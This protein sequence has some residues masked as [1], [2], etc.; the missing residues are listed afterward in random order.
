[1]KA[2]ILAFVALSS[3]TA[4][5][6]KQR[7]SPHDTISNGNITITYGRPYKNNRTIFAADGLVKWGEVWRLGADEATTISFAKPTRFGT[8]EVQPGTYTLFAIPGENE[9]T[10]ILNGVLGQWGAFKYADN[11]AKDVAKITVKA[12]QASTPVEQFTIRFKKRKE[13]EI[14][15]D[16]TRVGI[17][18]KAHK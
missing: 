11:A 5:G 4:F 8:A 12:D 14:S 13:V 3:I 16:R 18:V 17:P 9:W 10:F 7:K 2:F 6:Q 1:M 15:W